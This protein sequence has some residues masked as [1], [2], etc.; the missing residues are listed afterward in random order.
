M[1]RPCVAVLSRAAP[2]LLDV[3]YSFFGDGVKIVDRPLGDG[4]DVVTSPEGFELQLSDSP[5]EFDE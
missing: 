4:P 3:A 1:L 2:T 5:F